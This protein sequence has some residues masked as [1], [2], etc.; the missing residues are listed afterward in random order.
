MEW[1]IVS[2]LLATL[3]VALGAVVQ[4]ATGLGAGLLVVPLLALIHLQLVPGPVIFASLA[5]SVT[6]TLQGRAHI[7]RAYLGTVLSGLLLGTL[8][9]GGFLSVLPL[10]S[11]GMVFGLLILLA[12]VLSAR[13][14][15]FHLSTPRVLGAGM[16]AGAMGTAAGIGAPVLALLY[17]QLAGPSLRAT[18]ALLYA[19]SSVVVLIVLHILGRFGAGEAY[20]G[21][22]LV[23]GYVA[24]FLLAPRLAHYIDRGH[25]R[26]AVLWIS[27]LSALWLIAHSA[28]KVFTG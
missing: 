1:T 23:P 26:P 19:L 2:W 8:V 7:E 24:G 22:A 6:M 21:L 10:A 17:Q 28:M 9:T 4:A 5:L 20:A 25:A 18:L 13:R 11:L 16:L 14:P 27:S 15:Q 12:V 3:T